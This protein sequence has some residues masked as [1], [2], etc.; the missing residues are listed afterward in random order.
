MHRTIN[1]ISRLRE[2]CSIGSFSTL[3][4]VRVDVRPANFAAGSTNA[5]E[6]HGDADRL[7]RRGISINVKHLERRGAVEH[8]HPFAGLSSETTSLRIT[9]IVRI[10]KIG[11][12]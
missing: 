1:P 8:Q 5:R 11:L 7:A 10:M 9:E 2:V 6:E 4:A 3:F 12:P